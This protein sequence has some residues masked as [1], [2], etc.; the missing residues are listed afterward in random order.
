MTNPINLLLGIP[1]QP[2]PEL[3]LRRVHLKPGSADALDFLALLDQAASTARPKAVYRECYIEDRTDDKV[4]VS[5][6]TFQSR[7]LRLNLDQAE[8]VFAFVATCGR[9]LD[10]LPLPAGDLLAHY[11]LDAIKAESLHAAIHHLHTTL[12]NRYAL[13]KTGSMSPGS[14]DISVWA[15]EQQ[16][17]LF[18][19]LE[20]QPEQIGVSLTESFLMVPN[21]TVSGIYFPTEKAIRTCQVCKRENCPSRQAAFDLEA[22]EMIQQ[23]TAHG[24]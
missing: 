22:W 10:A 5:G 13:A 21:K 1:F 23:P 20:D 8:R 11:W 19:L 2:D 15:I 4:R 18:S 16:K 24:I 7:T 17:Q 9:E 14:G 3:L 6:V 12:E